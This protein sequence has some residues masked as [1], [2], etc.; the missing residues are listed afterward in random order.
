M[1]DLQHEEHTLFKHEDNE[2]TKTGMTPLQENGN[3][4][5]NHLSKGMHSPSTLVYTL[6]KEGLNFRYVYQLH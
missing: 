4:K 2:K 3:S 6:A 1:D 5:T